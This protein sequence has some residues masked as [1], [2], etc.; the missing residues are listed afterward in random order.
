MNTN[1]KNKAIRMVV[2]TI[3]LLVG[4]ASIIHGI[5]EVLQ[6]NIMPDSLVTNAIGQNQ[7]I[8]EYAALHTFTIIPNMIATGIMSII[9]GLFFT[10]WATVF[11]SKKY[12]AWIMFILSILLFLFGGG[13]GPL[14]IGII[15][16]IVATRINKPLKWWHKK[17]PT[18][19]SKILSNIWPWIIYFYILSYIFSVVFAITGFPFILIL[20]LPTTYN[21]LLSIGYVL[22]FL[23]LLVIGSAFSID[24]KKMN[25]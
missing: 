7:K 23:M 17:I 15:I 19:V 13:S 3:G 11:I 25:A 6:G 21:V 9:F 18:F 2:S 8:W 14:F 24:S 22:L 20:D 10:L 12:G 16:S 1:I 4:T 5:F